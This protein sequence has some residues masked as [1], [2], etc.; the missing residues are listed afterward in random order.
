MA[1]FVLPKNSKV[2]PGKVWP[3][4]AGQAAPG[5]PDLPLEPR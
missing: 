3:K 5:F 4:P 2:Q 1:E